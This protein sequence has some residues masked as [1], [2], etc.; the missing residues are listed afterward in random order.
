MEEF[1]IENLAEDLLLDLHTKFPN[2]IDDDARLLVGEL[3]YEK[4]KAHGCI[5]SGNASIINEKKGIQLDFG[6]RL[7]Q[8]C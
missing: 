1:R 4:G 5:Y 8:I 7:Y 3:G 2:T 6:I